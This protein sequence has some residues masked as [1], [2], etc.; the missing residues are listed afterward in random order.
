MIPA[1]ATALFY[2]A[3]EGHAGVIRAVLA[4]GAEVDVQVREAYEGM[5][6]PLVMA[7]EGGHLDAVKALL[8]AGAN[9]R[10]RSRS[11]K[12]ALTSAA[13]EGHTAVV[14]VL[15]AAIK[16]T[17]KS[18][19]AFDTPLWWA[20]FNSHVTCVKLLLAA[21]ASPQASGLYQGKSKTALDLARKPRKSKIL[22]MLNSASKPKVR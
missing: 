12:T 20:V 8:A 1:A 15:I 13:A 3:S 18:D 16:K 22:A 21:G 11:G 7:A 14:S 5:V 10:H 9:V 6:T 19:R 4:A 17:E 2:A